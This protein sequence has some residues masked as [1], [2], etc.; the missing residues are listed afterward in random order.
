MSELRKE[1]EELIHLMDAH[2]LTGLRVRQGE[3]VV[4]LRREAYSVPSVQAPTAAVAPAGASEEGISV[5]SPMIGV[6][7]LHPSPNEP[8]F[9]QVGDRVEVGQVIGLIEAMKV[10]NEVTSPAAGTVVK[11]AVESGSLVQE[12]D[13]LLVLKP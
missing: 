3:R 6:F 11:I 4:E 10:F 8:P 7:Y 1:I 12:G 13:T 2:G 5:P 9:V